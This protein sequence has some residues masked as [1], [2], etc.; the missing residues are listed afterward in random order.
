MFRVKLRALKYTKEFNERIVGA[1]V[2]NNLRHHFFV[3]KRNRKALR[4]LTGYN[5]RLN[6]KGR[7]M[8][9]DTCLVTGRSRALT[10]I[11]LSR[12]QIRK[13][14]AMGCVPGLKKFY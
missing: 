2:L 7:A 13:I 5:T 14:A 11:N 8:I 12:M 1:R 10:T 9:K 6:F 4:V 3:V